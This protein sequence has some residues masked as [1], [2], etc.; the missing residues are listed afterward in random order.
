MTSSQP[1]QP[2][3]CTL[4]DAKNDESRMKTCFIRLSSQPLPV[5]RELR[6]D[7]ILIVLQQ[8]DNG[9]DHQNKSN[10]RNDEAAAQLAALDGFVS[11]SHFGGSAGGGGGCGRCL[12][13]GDGRRCYES[14]GG[15]RSD[16]SL[17][18]HVSFSLRTQLNLSVLLFTIR[19][20]FQCLA[21]KPARTKSEAVTSHGQ[22]MNS[23]R[24]NVARAEKF[25]RASAFLRQLPKDYAATSTDAQML[26]I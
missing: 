2:F 21:P 25:I 24:P 23:E 3:R 19:A 16:K 7:A 5:S 22:L 4:A 12:S 8:D 10:T 6:A 17:E 15:S 11:R 18:N 13:R 9:E 1:L 14:S 20:M 26:L